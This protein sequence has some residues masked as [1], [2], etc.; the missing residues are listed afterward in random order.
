MKKYL[1]IKI[2]ESDQ[3]TRGDYNI[4]RGW[5]IPEDENPEDDGYLVKYGDDHESWSPVDVFESAYSEFDGSKPFSSYGKIVLDK[6]L[7]FISAA[8]SS[9]EKSILLT[10][11]EDVQLWIEHKL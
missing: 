7:G 4:Y 1:G 5:T 3:M 11:I 8:P 9:R 2:I 6:F 10:K